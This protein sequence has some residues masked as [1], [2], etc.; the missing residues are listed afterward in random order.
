MSAYGP[1]PARGGEFRHVC[2]NPDCPHPGGVF[3]SD[4]ERQVYCS[5]ACKKQV[6]NAAYYA[7]HRETILAHRQASKAG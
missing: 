7:R 2:P 5:N 6:K 1:E 4:S 3:H